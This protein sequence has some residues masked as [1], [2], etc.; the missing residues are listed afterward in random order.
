MELDF[1]KLIWQAS[2]LVQIVI[3]LLAAASV[4]SWA[5]IA[6]KLRELGNAE[7]DSEAFLAA[8]HQGSFEDA[9][10][11]AREHPR[12]P[13][14][15]VMLSAVGELK[16]IARYR[17]RGEDGFDASQLRAVNKAINWA[18]SREAL[19]LEGRLAFLATVGSASPFV[20]LF[21][22][23]VGIINAFVSIGVT[24]S[25]GLETVA[26]GIAEALIAT[27][28]GLFA[29]IP[30]TIFYNAFVAR[31]RDLNAAIDIFTGDLQDD[32]AH[33]SAANRGAGP[34]ALE[35]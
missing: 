10:K 22:T 29:A 35:R 5:A 13:L 15:A 8:Y 31:L 28:I 24:G 26:P 18:G 4:L 33:L 7:Q 32:I 30:A 14:S 17:G 34:R 21:G 1:F 6:F 2:L 16:R 20:G 27:A 25:A 12:S 19:R 23:V 3:A 11:A 9:E